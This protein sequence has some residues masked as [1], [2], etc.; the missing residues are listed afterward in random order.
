MQKFFRS[1]QLTKDDLS[2]Y[3]SAGP[4]P[5][6]FDVF[7]ITFT[8]KDPAG[9]VV[10]GPTAATRFDTGYYF[11]NWQIP[12][13]AELGEGWSITWAWE[14]ADGDDEIQ[15]DP[16]TFE[17]L[18]YAGNPGSL[19]YITPQDVYNE[20]V[21][22]EK[23][24]PDWVLQRIRFVQGYIEKLTQNRFVKTLDTKY[25]DG[26][27]TGLLELEEPLLEALDISFEINRGD[28]QPQS[29]LDFVVY[30]QYKDRGYP[31]VMI[32]ETAKLSI[33]SAV[34]SGVFPHGYQ[35]IKIHGY[36]GYTDREGRTPEE[37]KMACKLI[38]QKWLAP[39]NAPGSRAQ[40]RGGAGLKSQ[41]TDGHS[42]SLSEALSVG[43]LT[44][45]QEIDSLLIPYCQGAQVRLAKGK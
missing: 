1:Q 40:R 13:G 45:D 44:G 2:W 6:P 24:P 14:V 21:K 22:R 23:Y 26:D 17:V 5:T 36:W 43:T 37:I 42:Y 32:S 35:N 34:N 9:A 10:T 12:A 8:I 41:S 3:F 27:N 20:K 25:Y 33:Y 7:A 39:T 16:V 19:Y 29:L 18:E 4:A 31:R 30:N 28:Y 38:V 11:A 15:A